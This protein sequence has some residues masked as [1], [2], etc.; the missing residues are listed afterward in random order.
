[1]PSKMIMTIGYVGAIAR[2]NVNAFETNPITLAGAALCAANPTCVANRTLQHFFYPTH[3]VLPGD[4]FAS[5]GQQSTISN[6]SYNSL[7]ATIRKQLTH[8]L[9]FLA[10]Y[11]WSH[12][13]DTASSFENSG[14]GTRGT[15][16][17]NNALDKGDS[18]FDARQRLV[19]SYVYEIPGIGH[20]NMFMKRAF[21]GWKFTG[22]TTLQTGFPITLVDS[23][24]RSLT[25]DAF[26]YYDCADGPNV[27]GPVNT[28]LD[29]RTS[30][31]NGRANYWFDPNNFTR[32]VIGTFGSSGRGTFS[33]PGINN[34]DF[35]LL[36][37]TLI[38][39]RVRM[40]WRFEAYNAFN[41][42]Q[43]GGPGTNIASASTFGRITS[44]QIAGRRIQLA[45]KIYF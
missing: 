12:S 44:T 34:T 1:L 36:K 5:V 26:V 30:T 19:V 31:F 9:D 33:G 37:D 39:E 13:L 22:I 16:P 43:F 7:Q 27:K 42:T 10:A 21:G 45:A 41:H 35:A 14:F 23:G 28:N 18:A 29:P 24:F 40:E 25:C 20:N 2:H 3:S 6:S 8:G 17:F 32:Q 38:A 15:N 4:I 11:T